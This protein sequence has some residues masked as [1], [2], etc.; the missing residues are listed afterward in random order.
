MTSNF[1]IQ[2]VRQSGKIIKDWFSKLRSGGYLI[3]SYPTRN[4]FSRMEKTCKETNIEY[5]GLRFTSFKR[6]NQKFQI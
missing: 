2:L 3:I 5:S 6:Y 4:S 1:C